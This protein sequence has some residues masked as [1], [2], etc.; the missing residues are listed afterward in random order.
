MEDGDY[1]GATRKWTYR[2]LI[3]SD[4]TVKLELCLK[5]YAFMQGSSYKSVFT[6]KGFLD[7]GVLKIKYSPLIETSD[8]ILKVGLKDIVHHRISICFV[9]TL[10]D[11]FILNGDTVNDIY[12]S[13]PILTKVSPGIVLNSPE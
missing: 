5:N 6:G 13:F 7:N 1:F 4:K 11:I 2:L 3:Y 9:N 8:I 12:N 10:P